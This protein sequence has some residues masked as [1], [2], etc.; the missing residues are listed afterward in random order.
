LAAF[1][2]RSALDYREEF[3]L[4]AREYEQIRKRMGGGDRRTEQM[5]LLLSRAQVLAG[6]RDAGPAAEE[7]F[8]QATDG[9]RVVALALARTDPK[10]HHVEMAVECISHRRS[11]FEQ[12]HALLL[13]RAIVGALDPTAADQLSSAIS[14]QMGST[15]S[16]KDPSRWIIAKQL[17]DAI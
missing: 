10:R 7:L 3:G 5:E 2:S 14:R 16:E 4:L 13:A 1:T 9:S 12:Y 11:P 15:I 6:Q 17:I 8:R